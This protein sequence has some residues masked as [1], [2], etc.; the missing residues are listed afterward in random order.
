MRIPR[1]MGPLSY[2]L[3]KT[4]PSVRS[5]PAEREQVKCQDGTRSLPSRVQA[6]FWLVPQ[7]AESRALSI[8][9]HQPGYPRH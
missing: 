8:G 4:G 9:L 7:N 5:R 3:V 2:S 6:L 1:G